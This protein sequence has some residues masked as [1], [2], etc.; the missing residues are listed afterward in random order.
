[1][2]RTVCTIN[3]TFAAGIG[4]CCFYVRLDA[5]SYAFINGLGHTHDKHQQMP[6]FTSINLA[7]MRLNSVAIIFHFLNHTHTHCC[8]Q[9]PSNCVRMN[10]DGWAHVCLIVVSSMPFENSNGHRNRNCLCLFIY[11]EL[12][13]ERTAL[14]LWLLLLSPSFIE[15]V[16]V[17]GTFWC[18]TMQYAIVYIWW[19]S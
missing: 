18:T 9:T 13:C 1:M 7:W 17:I 15:C 2:T 11:Y 8:P 5:F 3:F 19:K 16:I 12:S 10:Q 6:V 4:N 14:S